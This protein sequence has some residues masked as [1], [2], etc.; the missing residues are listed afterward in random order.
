MVFVKRGN[1]PLGKYQLLQIDQYCAL[2]AIRVSL[3]H[4]HMG[5]G[6]DKCRGDKALI[7]GTDEGDID[8]MRGGDLT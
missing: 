4:L 1:L 6:G 3:G 5:G 7:G 2:A 8:L